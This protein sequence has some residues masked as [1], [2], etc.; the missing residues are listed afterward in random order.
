MKEEEC[1]LHTKDF[2]PHSCGT[3]LARAAIF[4]YKKKEEEQEEEEERKK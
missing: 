2:L 3:K 4:H 1:S